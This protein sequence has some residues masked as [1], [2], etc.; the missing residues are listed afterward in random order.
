MKRSLILVAAV[1]CIASV[2]IPVQAA[3][4]KWMMRGRGLYVSPN[5]SDRSRRLAPPLAEHPPVADQAPGPLGSMVCRDP[6]HAGPK[7]DRAGVL[8]PIGKIR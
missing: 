3:D 8:L 5:A 1:L 2:L 7:L 4:G 6:S